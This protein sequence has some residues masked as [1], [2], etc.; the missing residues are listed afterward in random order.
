MNLIA[1][2]FS[3]LI[4][5]SSQ[6]SSGKTTRIK[7]KRETFARTQKKVALDKEALASLNLILANKTLV[8]TGQVKLLGLE[9]IKEKLG[10]KWPVL[11]D[12][13]HESLL[14]ITNKVIQ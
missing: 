5:K 6:E 3:S 11:K 1:E 14:T 9:N 8:E 12:S 4:G 10:K 2:I 13:I 7:Q